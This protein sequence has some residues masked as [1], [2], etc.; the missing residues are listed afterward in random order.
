MISTDP[1]AGIGYGTGAGGTVTQ[2]TSRTTPVTINKICG[3]IVLF[4]DA[5][6]A[7][8]T[9]F[10]VNNTTV[11][12]NDTIIVTTI[13]GSNNYFAYANKIVD[14]TSFT[15]HFVATSGTASDTPTINFSIIKS[16][17]S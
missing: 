6:V 3:S 4:T 9:S 7:T 8:Y 16:V 2:G 15:I 10:V 13:G 14:V 5:G 12:I 17:T 11:S 1:T